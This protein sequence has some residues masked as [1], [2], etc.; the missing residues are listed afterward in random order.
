MEKHHILKKTEP[1]IYI[2]RSPSSAPATGF[3]KVHNLELSNFM[4][5]AFA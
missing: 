5:E 3:G 1:V 4:K 2:G